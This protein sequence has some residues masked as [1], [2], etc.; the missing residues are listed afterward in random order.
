M[1]LG[2]RP[3][4]PAGIEIDLENPF[5]LLGETQSWGNYV[6]GTAATFAR[7]SAFKGSKL[8]NLPEPLRAAARYLR[9]HY[10]MKA[11]TRAGAAHTAGLSDEFVD[12]FAVIGPPEKALPR[13]EKLAALGLDFLRVVPGSTDMPR[14]LASESIMNLA[15]LVRAVG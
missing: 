6:R 9:E 8:E 14:E 4:H 13:F 2:I 11:H 1:H 12:W 5:G 3:A 10:D 7:F 15:G